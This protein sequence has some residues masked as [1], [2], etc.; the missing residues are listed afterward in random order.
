M[1]RRTKLEQL[2]LQSPDDPFLNYALALEQAKEGDVA[3]AVSNLQKLQETHSEYVPTYFQ[4]AQLQV[5]LG[6]HA[7]A[8]PVLVAGIEMA[9]R[10]GDSHAEGELRGLLDQ[11]P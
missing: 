3:G 11:L 5:S 9:R 10:M 4:L 2:L 1:S 7:A 6:H 8:K